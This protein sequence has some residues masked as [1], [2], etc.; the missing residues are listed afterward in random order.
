MNTEKSTFKYAL[1]AFF[2][3]AVPTITQT[4]HSLPTKLIPKKERIEAQEIDSLYI[5]TVDSTVSV[6]DE[7]ACLRKD[8]ADLLDQLLKED[9]NGSY[10]INHN[11]RLNGIEIKFKNKPPFFIRSLLKTEYNF[12][13]SS[14]KKIWYR[15]FDNDVFFKVK[16]NLESFYCA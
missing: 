5:E 7:D 11:F 10:R 8:A 12:S 15:V 3:G 14:R 2:K 1:K 9:L 13:F 4:F 16:H 6:Q